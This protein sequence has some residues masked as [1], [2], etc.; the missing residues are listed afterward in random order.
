MYDLESDG[1]QGD[2]APELE[3]QGTSVEETATEEP[4]VSEETGGNPAWESVRNK[5]D[6]MLF[7]SIEE[8]L[9]GFDKNA[10]SRI[11]SLNK[12][13]SPYKEFA[14]NGI[15]P[16]Q[17]SRAMTLAQ[18]LDE[19]PAEIYQRLGDYLKSTG[20]LPE[21]KKEIETAL[22]GDDEA[23]DEQDPRLAKLE[24]QQQKIDNY[25]QAQAQK[26][27]ADKADAALNSEISTLRKDHP[28]MS[29]ADLEEVINRAATIGFLNH[30]KGLNK[31]PKLDEVYSS[32]VQYRNS[33]LQTPR[34]GESA[35]RLIPTNGGVPSS[36]TGEKKSLGQLSSNETADLFAG[37]LA[38]GEG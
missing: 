36:V 35:P 32:V 18:Q 27:I 10:Q 19:N 31:T 8:D 24:E 22:E 37:L 33:V 30:Q 15:Q 1:T 26:E 4:T 16:D 28:E 9:K 11:E 6:P 14:D 3:S 12:Q 25:F 20:H 34:S 38:A 13:Y 7:K 29:D 23:L 17:L 5:L 2:E 21:T